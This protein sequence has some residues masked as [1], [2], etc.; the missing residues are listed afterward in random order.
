M[1]VVDFSQENTILGK[2]VSEI[3]D[4]V[5]QKDSM[6]FRRNLERMGE[7][8]AIEI[9]KCLNYE[10]KE[11]TTPLGIAQCR[12]PSD[13]IVAATILRAGIPVHNGVL[14][15]FDQAQNAFIAAHRKYGKDNKFDIRVEYSSA[16][17]LEGKVLILADAM[18]ATG[19][20]L[21]LAYKKLCES[22]EPAHTH[23]ICAIASRQAMETLSKALPHKRVTFW[24]GA[25]DDELTLKS[26]II[27]GLG[28]AGDLCYGQK[29]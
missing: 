9:S 6:R 26:Y 24:V 19:S 21:L 15:V 13:Q 29:M 2:Y 28:D 8:F 17:A 22:G 27:P 4:K 5:V 3:R 18:V 25:V 20:S 7:L 12:V 11:V 1:K 14:N 10:T 23:F 16:P